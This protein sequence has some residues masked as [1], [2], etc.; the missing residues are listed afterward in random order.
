MTKIERIEQ[1]A[2]RSRVVVHN[3][4]AYLSG[5]VPDDMDAGIT[6]QTQ[7]VLAKIDHLLKLAGTNKTRVL[8]AQIWL[9]SMEDFGAMNAVWDAWVEQGQAPARCCGKVE[10]NNPKCRVEIMVTAA[11]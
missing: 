10:L 9:R 7:Q 2:R 8:N 1:T 3:N 5:N 11:I 6:V 4:V